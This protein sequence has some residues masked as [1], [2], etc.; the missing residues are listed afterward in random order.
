MAYG[1]VFTLE[2][3]AELLQ[4]V[5]EADSFQLRMKGVPS[6]PAKSTVCG[7]RGGWQKGTPSLGQLWREALF[8][9]SI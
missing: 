3:G 2:S 9:P 7:R 6:K 4:A 1:A 8:F 5:R